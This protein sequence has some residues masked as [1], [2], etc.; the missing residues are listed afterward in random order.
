MSFFDDI[1]QT[2]STR[3]IHFTYATEF[4]TIDDLL[5]GEREAVANAC[6]SRQREFA[7]GRW[8][9]RRLLAEMRVP[10]GEIGRGENNEAIWP[11]GI[12]GSI[13][14]TK[15]AC[16]V[17]ASF[18]SQYRSV[19]IDVEK[20][21]RQ[22]SEPARRL[23]LNKDETAWINGRPGISPDVYL[24][25]FSI[26]ESMYKMLYPLVKIVIPFSAVS[27]RPLENDGSF[28]CHVNRDLAG[29][30][31]SGSILHGLRF[32]NEDWLLTVTALVEKAP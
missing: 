23:F 16:C 7:T 26:K 3:S 31:P 2:L 12:C 10:S 11:E 29:T 4:R 21:S 8:C 25:I 32:K 17:V 13:T 20:A 15:G 27:V 1:R 24:T 9:A 14:H 18:Q 22:I 28:S 6:D 30:I 19:G 5:P